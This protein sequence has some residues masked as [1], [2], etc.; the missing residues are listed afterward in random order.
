MAERRTR[1]L[2][3]DDNKVNRLLLSRSLQLQGHQVALAEN[4]RQALQMLRAERF[5]L[6]LLDIE[7]PE[8]DGFGVLERLA[9]DPALREVPVIVTSSPSGLISRRGPGSSTQPSKWNGTSGCVAAV[10]AETIGSRSSSRR[11]TAFSAT[12]E[13]RSSWKRSSG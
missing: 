2:V 12:I 11:S 4:G 7:M 6:L 5:D 9:A 10:G 1:L 13:A 3:A 8:L